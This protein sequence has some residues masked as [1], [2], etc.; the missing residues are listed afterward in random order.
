M[1]LEWLSPDKIGHLVFYGILT[2]W[3]FWGCYRSCATKRPLK[4]YIYGSTL[5]A[6]LYGAAL[7]G[8][9]ARLPHRQFDYADMLANCIGALLALGCWYYWQ[10]R[11]F[12][13][14]RP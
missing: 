9:Q 1:P 2:G 3:L 6:A 12:L 10:R 4:R 14:E 13:A 8:V 7:E 5:F 11:L